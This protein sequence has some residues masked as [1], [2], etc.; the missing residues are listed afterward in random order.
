MSQPQPKNPQNPKPQPNAPKAKNNRRNNSRRSNNQNPQNITVRVNAAP[1]AVGA[2]VRTAAPRFVEKKGKIIVCHAELIGTL[3]GTE[4][5][6]T[7]TYSL[8]AGLASVFLWLSNV[9]LNYESYRFRKLHI[10]F[11]PATSSTTNGSVYLS[12]D[13]DAEDPAPYSEQQIANYSDTVS[14]VPWKPMTYKCRASDLSKRK[15]YFTRSDTQAVPSDL[16]LYD[17][18]NLIIATVG[19]TGAPTLGKIWL[20]YEVELMTPDFV[21]T[22]AGRSI[23][24][25]FAASDN[26]ATVPTITGSLPLT[27]T[28]NAN[29]LTLTSSAPYQ[30]LVAV[31]LAAASGLT[32]CSAGGSATISERADAVNSGGTSCVATYTVNFTNSGQTMTIAATA[33]TVTAYTIRV[34][35]YSTSLA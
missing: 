2:Q 15:S 6:T 31:T 21:I 17:T 16:G 14:N 8:N 35:Q 30:G 13:Y 28:V 34:G 27:P 18:G 32:G 4:A 11:L 29:V 33:G 10:K 12:V 20:D 23:A 26:F 5:F 9:A 3:T 25:K 1:A 19:N 22:G 7:R 24:G